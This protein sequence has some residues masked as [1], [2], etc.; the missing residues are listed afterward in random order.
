MTKHWRPWYCYVIIA[1][2]Y[3]IPCTFW[4]PESPAYLYSVGKF[5]ESEAVIHKIAMI[6][7]VIIRPD[8]LNFRELS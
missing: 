7:G 2:F 5:E 6:N 1:Y 3:T 4:L 8:T